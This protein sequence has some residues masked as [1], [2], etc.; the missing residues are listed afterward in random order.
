MQISSNKQKTIIPFNN[1]LIKRRK[2]LTIKL[3][4]NFST[5]LPLIAKFI[6]MTEQQVPYN[7]TFE[8]QSIFSTEMHFILTDVNKFKDKS[9]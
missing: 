9:L 6:N 1:L 2:N 7:Q 5:Q 4:K 3:K 8:I